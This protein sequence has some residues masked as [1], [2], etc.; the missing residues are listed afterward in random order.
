MSP[1]ALGLDEAGDAAGAAPRAPPPPPRADAKPRVKEVF[2]D[3]VCRYAA[4]GEWTR[5]K[6]ALKRFSGGKKVG[7]AGTPARAPLPGA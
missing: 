5:A 4:A 6:Q 2:V 3:D 7:S 1:P